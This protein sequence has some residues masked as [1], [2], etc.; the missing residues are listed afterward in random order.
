MYFVQFLLY[1]LDVMGKFSAFNLK[2]DIVSA[3]NTLNY[4]NPTSI[5]ELVIPK[6][7][8]GESLVVKSETGSGK[9]HSFLIPIINNIDSNDPRLQTII[10]SPTRELAQ[11]TYDFACEFLNFYPNLN[12]K[13]ISSSDEPNK[14]IEALKSRPQILI[15]TCGRLKDLLCDESIITLSGVKTIVLDEADM[16]LENGFIEDASSIIAKLN[17]P[18]ILVFSATINRNL[19]NILLKFIESKFFITTDNSKY[20][21]KNVKHFAIDTKHLPLNECLS[22]FMKMHP[23]YFLMIFVSKKTDIEP[24]YA[25]LLKK[26]YKVAKFHGDLLPRERKSLMKRI[27][28]DEFQIVV[29]SDIASRGID[30]P[31]CDTV[32]SVDL[33]VD[34]EF[35]YHR[36]GRTGRYD[37]MGESYIFYDNDHDTKIKELLQQGLDL[38][39]VKFGVDNFI[40]IKP[41]DYKKRF[42]NKKNPELSR[43]I[44][45]AKAKLH[46][47]KV[48]PNYKKK[49]RLAVEKVKAKHRREIIKKDIRR[50]RVERY[51]KEGKK[52]E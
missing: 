2:A 6:V 51:K 41:L 47:S 38:N 36:A 11:Q 24:I 12:I 8:N 46:T 48:K 43:E 27:K 20:T 14:S 28:N 17:K 9:T 52:Y 40:E 21:S 1:Y 33:P 26:K 44:S 10:V 39:F 49:M 25:Y 16:I 45:K 37:K 32:L 23:C 15:A 31:E 19:Q 7:L 30:L 18:Q 4:V 34:L 42:V 13:L 35:Y 22:L 3:L 50:Q 5:Q 29:C